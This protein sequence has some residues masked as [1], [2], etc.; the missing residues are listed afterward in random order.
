MS[1]PRYWRR[2]PEYYR[3]QG[4]KCLV[5]SK[6]IFPKREVCNGCGS[7]KM[8]NYSFSRTGSIVTYTII[9]AGTNDPEGENKEIPACNIPYVLA[10]IRL[11]E[12]PRLTAQVV[13]TET[14]AIGDRVEIVFRRI[15]EKGRRGAIQY[16]YKFR[17]TN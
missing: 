12:G 11:D 7:F 8:E 13:D 17:L 14:A 4:K 10:I 15:L 2:I 9:R 3:L 1:A 16:G 5:C 6:L